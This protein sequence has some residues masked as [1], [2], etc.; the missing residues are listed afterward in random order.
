MFKTESRGNTRAVL[1]KGS[2]GECALF[3]VFV[4]SFPFFCTLVPAFGVREPPPKPA[5]WKPPFCEPATIGA[6][7]I[8]SHTFFL[9]DFP[10]YVII[11]HTT[12]LF[13]AHFPGYASSC[14]VAKHTMRRSDLRYIIVSRVFLAICLI[15]HYRIG[16][17]WINVGT[18]SIADPE[19]VS[20]LV[21]FIARSECDCDRY[22]GRFYHAIAVFIWGDPLKAIT[23]W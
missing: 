8:T 1:W 6:K 10:D 5:F 23:L 2:F 14:V 17:E 13:L 11:V 22:R 21:R 19:L 7:I 3:L 15:L 20:R 12:D 16:F 9:L 18:K 4:P